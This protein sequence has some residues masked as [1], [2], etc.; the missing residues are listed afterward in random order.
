M[1]LLLRRCTG[2]VNHLAPRVPVNVKNVFATALRAPPPPPPPS[3]GRLLVHGLAGSRLFVRSS[4]HT[5]VSPSVKSV[6]PSCC[7]SFASSAFGMARVGMARGAISKATCRS[8][9]SSSSSM[10]VNSSKYTRA[11]HTSAQRNQRY[12]HID[13][14]VNARSSWYGPGGGYGGGG[15][16]GG[17]D[18]QT[19]LTALLATNAGVYLLWMLA[20]NGNGVS[21]R[22]MHDH[23]ALSA[24]NL[25]QGRYHTLL[26]CSFS[27]RDFWH[28][29]SNG[30]VL[31]F[32]GAE[33]GAVF[34]GAFLLR[35]YAL[36]AVGGSAVHIAYDEYQYRQISRK[37]RWGT[38]GNPFEYQERRSSWHF[39]PVVGA[40]CAANAII[41]FYTL[42]YPFR[43]IYLYG[44]LPLPAWLLGV[45]AVGRDFV[46]MGA[47]D[48]TSHTGHIGG[49]AAGAAVKAWQLL[50]NRMRRM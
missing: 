16:G 21:E 12:R 3:L 48:A 26:T 44:L 42:T 7:S 5:I 30:V 36:G 45:L 1:S 4:S 27:H 34:G 6:V 19:A 46:N 39:R 2:G 17:I 11:V 31:F 32:F 9:A 28:L 43:P 50:G 13:L 20:A 15:G 40:S 37:R 25:N 10:I 24:H 38:F 35:L 33:L 47:F 23:F 29:I 18:G 41:V 49:A 22:F 8:N 14:S